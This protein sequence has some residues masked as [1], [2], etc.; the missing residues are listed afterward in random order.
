MDPRILEMLKAR[1]RA[2]GGLQMG[3][4][5]TPPMSPASQMMAQNTP[6]DDMMKQDDTVGTP[7]MDTPM[8]STVDSLDQL[9][10]TRVQPGSMQEK[11]KLLLQRRANGMMPNKA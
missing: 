5:E 3:Q 10:Q 4:P 2:A 1:A 6:M 7:A 11:L 8:D 9:Q